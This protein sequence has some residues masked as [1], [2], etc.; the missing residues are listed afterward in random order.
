MC[1]F[2]YYVYEGCGHNGIE[3]VS[4]CV[5]RLW[6][7]GINGQLWACPELQYIR[8]LMQLSPLIWE[9]KYGYFRFCQKIY[10]VSPYFFWFQNS[11]FLQVIISKCAVVGKRLRNL[12]PPADAR[13]DILPLLQ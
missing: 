8:N 10:A 2:G 11:L 6:E 4:H 1:L 7:A 12:M 13:S 9:G 5:E 3:V